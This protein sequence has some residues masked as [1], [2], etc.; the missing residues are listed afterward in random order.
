ME[1]NG[2]TVRALEFRLNIPNRLVQRLAEQTVPRKVMGSHP[3]VRFFSA[4]RNYCHRFGV[5]IPAKGVI[6]PQD[7]KERISLKEVSIVV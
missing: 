4:L 3:Q 6:L 1:G 2:R 7:R 5:L